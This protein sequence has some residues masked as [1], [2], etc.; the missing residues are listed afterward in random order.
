MFNSPI[1]TVTS[2]LAFLLL[3]GVLVLQVMEMHTYCM[4]PF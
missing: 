1:F 4:L 2:I 3:I